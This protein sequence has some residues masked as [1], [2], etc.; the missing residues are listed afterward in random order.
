M[1]VYKDQRARLWDIHT[2]EFWRSMTLD[3]A[4]ELLGQGGWTQL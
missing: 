4:E 2:K 3:K 1:L